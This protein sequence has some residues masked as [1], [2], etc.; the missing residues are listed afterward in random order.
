MSRWIRVFRPFRQLEIG[1]APGE[2]G[3]QYARAIWAS[4][5]K[6]EQLVLRQLAD[7]DVVNPHSEAV[8]AQLMRRGLV[9]RDRRLHIMDA[10]FQRF[11][12]RVVPA[13]EISR[14]EGDGVSL[15][16][17]SKATAGLT[18]AIGIAMAL[19]LTSQQMVDAWI[20]YMPA[21]AP[22]VPTMLKLFTSARD[23]KSAANG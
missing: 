20:G 12:L 1:L 4:S 21:L 19:V 13:D 10:A 22:A 14:R 2:T 18:V 17:A 15:P 8:V 23:P 5:S 11:V 7:E 16:W 6:S 9:R 3:E